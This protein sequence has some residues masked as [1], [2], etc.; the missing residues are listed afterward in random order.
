MKEHAWPRERLHEA[1]CEL[2]RRSGLT[3]KGQRQRRAL[4]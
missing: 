3:G 1:L 4:Q 2:L